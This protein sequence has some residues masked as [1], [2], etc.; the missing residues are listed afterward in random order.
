MEKKKLYHSLC[1]VYTPCCDI[2]LL[3]DT[4]LCKCTFR[5]NAQCI[6]A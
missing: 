4:F 1:H 5:A 2:Q 6:L 3:L